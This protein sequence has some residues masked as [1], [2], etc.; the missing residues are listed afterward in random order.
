MSVAVRPAG[1]GD[2]PHLHRL[3]LA[4]AAFERSAAPLTAA[5]LAALCG[6]D[7]APVR[8][9][10]AD[11]SANLLGYASVTFDWSTWRAARFAHLDCLFVAEGARG[12]GVGKRLLLAA[13]RLALSEGVER[14]EWQ[15]PAWNA[16]AAR[17]YARE[18]ARSQPKLRFSVAI[19]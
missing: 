18:G 7:A 12:A 4:H 8:L 10:V 9:L 17:F 14:M 19:P 2:A 3:I 16:D 11:R 1:P 5:A 6:A 13:K 15:T